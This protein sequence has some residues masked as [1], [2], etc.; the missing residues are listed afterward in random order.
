MTVKNN[1]PTNKRQK[2][3]FRGRDNKAK[4]VQSKGQKKIDD[5]VETLGYG[6]N[7]CRVTLSS[8]VI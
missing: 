2:R 7:L 6:P 1:Q 3:H 4:T 5:S 8:K